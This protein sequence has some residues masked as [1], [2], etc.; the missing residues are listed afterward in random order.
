MKSNNLPL[1]KTKNG[2]YISPSISKELLE[3][4]C[5]NSFKIII[6]KNKTK[7]N[8]FSPDYLMF[9]IGDKK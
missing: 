3:K 2:N 9:V 5:D 1:F 6:T 7:E 8:T 4:M